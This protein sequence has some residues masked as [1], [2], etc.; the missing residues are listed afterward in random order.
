MPK[1]SGQILHVFNPAGHLG[2]RPG[3]P[4]RPTPPPL[5]PPLL[6]F[7][8]PLEIDFID[9]SDELKNFFFSGTKIFWT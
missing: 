4:Y 2:P 3:A 1:L 5:L 7:G 8:H 6:K 9:V